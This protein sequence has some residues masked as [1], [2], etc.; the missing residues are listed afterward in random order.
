MK[1]YQAIARAVALHHA[2]DEL[3]LHEEKASALVREHMPSGSGFDSGTQ[4]D[5]ARSSLQKLVF[6]T[7]FHHMDAHGGYDGWTKHSVVLT[8][9]LDGHTLRVTGKDRNGIKAYISEVFW[10][11]LTDTDVNVW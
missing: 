4:L 6:T 8:A 3:G 10:S 9:N 1:L 2:G 11:A 7:D 5:V